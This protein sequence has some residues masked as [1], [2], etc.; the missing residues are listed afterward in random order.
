MS[1][2]LQKKLAHNIAKNVRAKKP[3]NKKELAV[4]SGY[5]EKH[6]ES[7]P[8]VIFNAQGVIKELNTLGFNEDAA[9][10]VVSEIMLSKTSKARDRLTA[11]DQVFKVHGTYAP[12]KR[13]TASVDINELHNVINEQIKQFRQLNNGSTQ[14]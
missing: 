11:T 5:S 13:L 10:A 4:S 6:A 2:I 1:T 12:E 3:L 7:H 14:G 8:E 9:K